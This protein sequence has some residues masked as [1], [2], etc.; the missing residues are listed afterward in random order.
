MVKP[1]ETLYRGYRFRSRL[2]ARWAVFFD[3]LRLGWEYEPEGYDTGGAGYYL[4]DFRVP[5]ILG[6]T[7]LYEIKP[8]WPDR[9]AL[10]KAEA[11]GAAIIVGTPGIKMDPSV[12]SVSYCILSSDASRHY[13]FA[14]CRYCGITIEWHPAFMWGATFAAPNGDMITWDSMGETEGHCDC[15]P[16]KDGSPYTDTD[17]LR[18]AYTAARSARFEFGEMLH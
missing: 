18:A 16:D 6:E 13:V 5:G 1:V 3:A 11:A 9:D 14:E 7:K 4:P 12:W 8:E 2:E 10:R 15:R 17:R